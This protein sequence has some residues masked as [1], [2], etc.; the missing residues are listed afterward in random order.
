M[1]SR[2]MVRGLGLGLKDWADRFRYIPTGI[3]ITGLGQRA[4]SIVPKRRC[5]HKCSACFRDLPGV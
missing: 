2:C 5:L 1:A 3:P 4:L